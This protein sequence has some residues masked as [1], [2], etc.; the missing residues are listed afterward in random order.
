MG[1]IAASG[2][3]G[4][5]TRGIERPTMQLLNN[6]RAKRNTDDRALAGGVAI[7]GGTGSLGRALAQR[8]AR[9]GVAV[10]IGSRTPSAARVA[11][12]GIPGTRG[13]SYAFAVE[14]CKVVVLTVPF[15]AHEATVKELAPLLGPGRIV[16]D[17][18]VP[19]ARADGGGV[20]PI[21]N[22]ALSAAQQ[23]QEI[24][25]A[26][27]HVVSAL[28]TVSAAALAD[29]DHTL[30]ED[31]LISGDDVPALN[32][33]TELI[34][35]IDGLR[36]VQAGSLDFSGVCEQLTPMIINV[37]RRYGT[38]AGIKI[39]GVSTES[40]DGP[41]RSG[42]EDN[43]A[44]RRAAKA[45]TGPAEFLRPRGRAPVDI[46]G[47]AWQLADFAGPLIDP[48]DRAAL[49]TDLGAGEHIRA[50]E[51]G[52][53]LLVGAREQLPPNLIRR[54]N[55][56]VDCYAGHSDEHRLRDLVF[57]VSVPPSAGS[58]AS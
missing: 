13:G 14:P 25:A 38:R 21:V 23:A 56:W 19:M 29:I 26:G 5:A 52:L 27:V 24:L 47:L 39:T 37:N 3:D 30:D 48:T 40:A 53:K 43:A 57:A 41:R 15:A 51:L 6:I 18:T 22:G 50:L 9:A 44:R 1:D 10:R 11:A 17:T 35:R 20:R 7:I 2:N 36:P 33:A 4:P 49:F 32:L 12:A 54:V 46:A 45:R 31:V 55:Q 58:A 34:G 42:S 16:V 28:H 8:W